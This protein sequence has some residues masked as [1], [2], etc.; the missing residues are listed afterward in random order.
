MV[1]RRFMA[2]TECICSTCCKGIFIQFLPMDKIFPNL[3]RIGLR[4]PNRK[5]IAMYRYVRTDM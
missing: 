3:G 1:W 5:V 2:R 4:F